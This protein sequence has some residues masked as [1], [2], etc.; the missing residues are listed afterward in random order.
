MPRRW[1]RTGYEGSHM[2]FSND[3]HRQDRRFLPEHRMPV[4]AA[5]GRR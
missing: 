2:N 1:Q 5:T 4:I 3:A